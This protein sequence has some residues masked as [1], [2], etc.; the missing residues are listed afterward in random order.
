[1]GHEKKPGSDG[2]EGRQTF[3]PAPPEES[4]RRFT[5]PVV[6]V[7]GVKNSGKTT[8]LAALLPRLKAKGL[9]V[10]FIKHDG[11]DFSPDPAGTDSFRLRGLGADPVAVYSPH[12]Y[13]ITAR[14][15]AMTVEDLLPHFQAV[16]LVLLEGG[17]DSPYPKIEV[18]R[19]DISSSPVCR[20]DTLLA[21]CTDTDFRWPGVPSLPLDA[22]EQMAALI[23]AH[24]PAQ[25]AASDKI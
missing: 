6:A 15:E 4:G 22:Y 20:P 14:R 17:K 23:A 21:L 24:L 16:D 18:L 19:R 2:L 12:R 25:P 11:H 9:R 1:M 10:G 7:S 8:L 3:S 5:P 13:M